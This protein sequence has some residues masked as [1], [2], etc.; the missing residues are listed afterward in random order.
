L[1]DFDR[2]SPFALNKSDDELDEDEIHIHLDEIKPYLTPRTKTHKVNRRVANISENEV[3][4]D[5]CLGD[6]GFDF[7]EIVICEMCF[8]GVH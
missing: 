1:T 4:C 7:N 3:S 6:Q 2:K 8:T 5:V